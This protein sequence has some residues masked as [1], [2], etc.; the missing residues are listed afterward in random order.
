MRKF[1][2]SICGYIYDEAI[3]D[4]ER[5]IAPGTKWNDVSEDWNCPL[6]GAMKSDFAEDK[7]EKKPFYQELR[8]TENEVDSIRELSFE[9]VSAFCSNFSKGC[10]KQYRLEE[11]ELFNQLAEF[12]NAK[13]DPAGKGQ[14]KDISTLIEQDLA[15]GY[16][17]ANLIAADASDRG[18]L[19]ALV[20]GEKVTRMVN[21]IL[22]RYEKQK[23]ALLENTHVYVCDICGFV[24]I[25]DELPEI[26]PVCKV[27]NKKITEIKRG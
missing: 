22:S 4:P 14:L 21:S 1:I 20:W 15:S 17:Q 26:C 5:G 2:C 9:E 18:A 23:D 11:A 16:V 24:F 10:T 19:R 25:G 13:S 27:P 12:Y 3:G 8:V 7:I 6:C